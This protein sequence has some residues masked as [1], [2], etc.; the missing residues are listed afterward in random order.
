MKIKL[1]KSRKPSRKSKRLKAGEN[2]L[3]TKN[4]A[5]KFAREAD[6]KKKYS[7]STKEELEHL[8]V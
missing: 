7:T 8:F 3:S 5:Y 4:E 6:L 1:L 2:L